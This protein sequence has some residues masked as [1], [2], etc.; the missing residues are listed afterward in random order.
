MGLGMAG[1]KQ[2]LLAYYGPSSEWKVRAARNLRSLGV[3]QAVSLFFT[4]FLNIAIARFLGKAEFGVY[5][6]A[7]NL[8]FIL[9]VLANFGLTGLCIREVARDT[10]RCPQYL[11][12]SLGLRILFTL[13]ASLL[14]VAVPILI[15]K[16]MSVVGILALFAGGFFFMSLADGLR[17]VFNAFQAMGYEALVRILE[18]T[19]VLGASVA[20]LVLG[21]GLS[22][23]ACV[24]LGSELL[25]F[26]LCALLVGRRF[27]P[28]AVSLEGPHCRQMLSQS[29]YFALS[30][31]FWSVYF[32]IDIVMLSAM[33]GDAPTGLYK[34][35]YVLVNAIGTA[36][37][38]FMTVLFPV[39]S[40]LYKESP[41]EFRHV[42]R[43]TL[44]LFN[45]VTVPMIVV[46]F[47]F[48][49]TIIDFLYSNRF[50]ES[51]NILR[52]LLFALFFLFPTSLFSNLLASAD[53]QKKIALVGG[54]GAALNIGLNLVLIP[55]WSYYGASVA[56]VATEA[57]I[58]CGLWLQVRS[59][60][61][62]RS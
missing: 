8:Q 60:L 11:S 40:R 45:I 37:M 28:V 35:A 41:D 32:Q 23:V 47:L 21:A 57:F 48:A 18:R 51:G 9:L 7:V 38:V 50:A 58:A 36:P 56:T 46:L 6:L 20:V 17:W 61:K 43:K 25:I 10:G 12:D 55:R 14:M 34:A 27:S 29:F 3:G 33:K 15:G 16:P 49:R 59:F 62:G 22:G 26:A 13:G 24:Y 19:L 2:K 30:E 31:L 53:R 42:Y 52:V 5:A 1:L 39:L 44:K 4:F 54:L